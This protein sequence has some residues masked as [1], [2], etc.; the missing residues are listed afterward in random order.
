M[1]G[2]ASSSYLRPQ[3]RVGTWLD[4]PFGQI[5]I[6]SEVEQFALRQFLDENLANHFS[7]PSVAVRRPIVRVRFLFDLISY[8]DA[9]VQL[10]PFILNEIHVF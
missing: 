3:D 1:Y 9:Q 5:Y 6:L 2:P 7:R 4:T 8:W 10:K